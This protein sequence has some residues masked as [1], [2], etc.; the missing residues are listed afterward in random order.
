MGTHYQGNRY[1][2]FTL[3]IKEDLMKIIFSCLFVLISSCCLAQEVSACY[4]LNKSLIKDK[5]IHIKGIDVKADI[6]SPL[7]FEVCYSQKISKGLC[8]ALS[9]EYQ[10]LDYKSSV[11]FDPN[12]Y[13]SGYN[14]P[15]TELNENEKS[16]VFHFTPKLSYKIFLDRNYN[17]EPY[18]AF[19]YSILKGGNL[20]FEDI[21]YSFYRYDSINNQYYFTKQYSIGYNSNFAGGHNDKVKL[22]II[23][24]GLKN[25]FNMTSNLSIF[26]DASYNWNRRVINSGYIKFYDFDDRPILSLD[27]N[28]K[29]VFWQFKMGITYKLFKKKL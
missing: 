3:F 28:D 8:L 1:P 17:I 13:L 7:D 10:N 18:L 23:R 26:I 29:Y 16:K 15:I 4:S 24:I 21:Y 22:Y 25:Q 20:R 5:E 27:Y 9:L 2:L 6:T 12:L 11:K 19:S 14:L